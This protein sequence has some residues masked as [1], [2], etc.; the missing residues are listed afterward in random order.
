MSDPDQTLTFTPTSLK[1]FSR[2][3]NLAIYE[4]KETFEFQGHQINVKY[5]MYLEPYVTRQLKG[6][7]D[8]AP[9]EEHHTQDE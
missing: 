1:E 5:A 4:G 2:R 6:V 9:E 3:L 7:D 8:S